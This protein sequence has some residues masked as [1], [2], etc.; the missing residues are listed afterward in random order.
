MSLLWCRRTLRKGLPQS[1]LIFHLWPHS[2]CFFLRSLRFPSAASDFRVVWLKKIARNSQNAQAEGCV[3]SSCA[4]PMV[5]LNAATFDNPDSLIVSLHLP[6]ISDSITAPALLDSGLSHCF[7][8]TTFVSRLSLKTTNIS[9][10]HLCLLDGSDA[11]F[12]T[13]VSKSGCN[14][15]KRPATGP[16]W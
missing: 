6:T 2:N 10:L 13:S 3:D 15:L 16:D 4:I 14:F 1:V 11:T 7:I 12:I 9:P 5:C 8:D